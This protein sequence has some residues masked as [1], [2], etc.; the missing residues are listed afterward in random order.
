MEHPSATIATVSDS[1][2]SLDTTLKIPREGDNGVYTQSWFPIC[3]SSELLPGAILGMPFLDGRVVAYRGA[4]GQPHVQ[5]AY[6]PHVGADLSVGRLVNDRIQCRFHKYEFDAAGRCVKTGSGDTP[7]NSARLFSFP[8]IE[9]Y[10]IIWAFNGE[11]P[12]FDFPKFDFPDNEL[13]TAVYVGPL[14]N[15]DGWV[16]SCNTADIQ[17]IV[18]VHEMKIPEDLQDQIDWGEWGFQYDLT[19]VHGLGPNIDWRVGIRGSSL[20]YHQG[21]VDDWW[22]GIIVGF[23]LP[24][25]GEHQA[26]VAIA[27]HRGSG[28]VKDLHAAQDHLRFSTALSEFTVMQDAP[29]LNS[30]HFRPRFFTR[31]DR[32]LAKFLHYMKQYPRANPAVSRLN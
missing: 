6:C 20:Y 28:S 31:A 30:I 8:T 24:R 27:V 26:F 17:H 21:T 11:T 10:G 3:R 32:A 13:E 7:P 16:F 9:R 2:S 15:C 12:L 29:I 14:T 1:S 18:S 5:T 23:S 4:D 19:G 22:L 25:G